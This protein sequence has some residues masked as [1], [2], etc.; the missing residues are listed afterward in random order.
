M[1]CCKVM[2]CH[3]SAQTQCII[4]QLTLLVGQAEGGFRWG[5]PISFQGVSK[6]KKSLWL[7]SQPWGH[8]QMFGSCHNPTAQPPDNREADEDTAGIRSSTSP[9]HVLLKSKQVLA[10]KQAVH[11]EGKDKTQEKSRI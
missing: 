8:E 10:K 7:C 9:S 2:L 3:V 4:A 5:S 11:K 1:Y 6:Q